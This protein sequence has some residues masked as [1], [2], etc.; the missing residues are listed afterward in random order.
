MELPRKH[1]SVLLSESIES[2]VTKYCKLPKKILFYFV[3]S[4]YALNACN[5]KIVDS[6]PH[7]KWQKLTT[8]EEGAVNPPLLKI[9]K[10]RP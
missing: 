2:H 8:V 4:K 3:L 9:S 7:A 5:K 1:L 6:M 10:F